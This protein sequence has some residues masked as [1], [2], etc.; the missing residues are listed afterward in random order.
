MLISKRNNEN[1][2]DIN[3]FANEFSKTNTKTNA[4]KHDVTKYKSILKR[5][6]SIKKFEC[7]SNNRENLRKI[8][9]KK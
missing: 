2:N 1:I 4:R 7:V 5:T 9:I 6:N 8:A 3:L